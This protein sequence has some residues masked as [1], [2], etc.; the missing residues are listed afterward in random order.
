MWAIILAFVSLL[1]A[2]FVQ[3]VWPGLRKSMNGAAGANT[4][5]EACPPRGG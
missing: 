3:W 4:L 2:G 5:Y 1:H